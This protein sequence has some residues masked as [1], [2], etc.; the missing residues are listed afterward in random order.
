MSIHINDLEGFPFSSFREF[1][2]ASRA[3]SAGLRVD[4]QV[5]ITLAGYGRFGRGVQVF[6]F[7]ML[8][9]PWA[10]IIGFAIYAVVCNAWLLLGLFLLLLTHFLSHPGMAF[11]R[12]MQRPLMT[13][14]IVI[15]GALCAY[16]FLIGHRLGIMLLEFSILAIVAGNLALLALPVKLL[17]RK[18]NS[19]EEFLCV[20]WRS[21]AVMVTT[22]GGREFSPKS[23]PVPDIGHDEEAMH[24]EVRPSP[25]INNKFAFQGKRHFSKGDW[26]IPNGLGIHFNVATLQAEVGPEVILI[27]S[28]IRT[29]L[30]ELRNQG[31]YQLRL[32]SGIMNTSAGPIIFLL[33]WFPPLIEGRPFAG[34]ELLISPKSGPFGTD[35][36][37]QADLQT[38]LHLV[39]LDECQEVF[40]VVE[41]ENT[42][43]LGQLVAA[44]EK[45]N[46]LPT[47]YDFFKAKEAFLREIPQ[48]RLLSV[49]I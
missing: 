31:P 1:Q 3:G 15:I 26:Q 29:F 28:E 11:I 35:L 4:T 32:N 36:L 44:T 16:E 22:A 12:R 25:I 42:Y 24:K 49:L 37:N 18:A 10:I 38:H 20:L 14:L 7:A 9:V 6:V 8:Y 48:E 39:I 33:W 21:N 40:A 27:F 30:I 23:N 2:T 41:F 17:I 46:P 45:V 19:E 47:G 34:Y 5:A 13:L 43:G